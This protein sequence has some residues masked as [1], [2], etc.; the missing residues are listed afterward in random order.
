MYR[1]KREAAVGA[2]M[3]KRI[4]SVTEIKCDAG[5]SGGVL[6]SSDAG[7][8]VILRSSG[9][10]IALDYYDQI[11]DRYWRITAASHQSSLP[12]PA[13]AASPW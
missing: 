13:R 2:G 9:R 4:E 7:R 3:S 10:E 8:L 5:G 11:T 12:K 1:A 6:G